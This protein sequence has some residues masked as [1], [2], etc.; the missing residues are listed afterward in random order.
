LE[1]KPKDLWR[2]TVHASPSTLKKTDKNCPPLLLKNETKQDRVHKNKGLPFFSGFLEKLLSCVL[3]KDDDL[4]YHNYQDASED[5]ARCLRHN[6]R[7]KEGNVLI[8]QIQIKLDLFNQDVPLRSESS[9][10]AMLLERQI[11]R[12]NLFSKMSGFWL[13]TAVR[14]TIRKT[15]PSVPQGLI[16]AGH[17]RLFLLERSG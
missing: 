12:D 5:T 14:F 3:I 9:L 6:S 1:E 7:H 11:K 2:R 15:P 17:R 10:K 4:R 16:F 8:L 13:D